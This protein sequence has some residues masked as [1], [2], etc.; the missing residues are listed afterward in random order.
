[1]DFIIKKVGLGAGKIANANNIQVKIF[2]LEYFETLAF[3]HFNNFWFFSI[4]F[5]VHFTIPAQNEEDY[6]LFLSQ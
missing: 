3:Y 4:Y 2:I 6:H 5:F 1:M